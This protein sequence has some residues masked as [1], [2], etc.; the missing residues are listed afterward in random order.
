MEHIIQLAEQ[1][2]NLQ[3]VIIQKVVIKFFHIHVKEDSQGLLLDEHYGFFT[4]VTPSNIGTKN[5]NEL[6]VFNLS[7]F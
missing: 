1:L 6:S 5:L 7:L 2:V 4:N 3:V